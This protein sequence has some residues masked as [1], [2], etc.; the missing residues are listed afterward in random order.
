MIFI[1]H[2]LKLNYEKGIQEDN[3]VLG[4]RPRSTHDAESIQHNVAEIHH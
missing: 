1:H 4:V 2:L 3:I